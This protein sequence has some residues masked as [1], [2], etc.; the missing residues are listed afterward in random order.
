[1]AA[2]EHTVRQLEILVEAAC[3][4]GIVL[5]LLSAIHDMQNGRPL[6]A[7]DARL[8]NTASIAALLARAERSNRGIDATDGADDE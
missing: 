4:Y 7:A 5:E 6:D 3:H 8:V 1:M 2:T